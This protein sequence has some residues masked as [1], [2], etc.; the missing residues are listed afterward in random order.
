[1][2]PFHFI[3]NLPPLPE[4]ILH[5]IPVLPRPTRSTPKYTLV[6]DLVS[7]VYIRM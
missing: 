7:Q 4:D 3:K 2:T 5:R 6:L 1:M